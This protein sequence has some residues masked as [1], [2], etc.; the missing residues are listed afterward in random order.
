MT[1]DLSASLQQ[2]IERELPHLGALPESVTDVRPAG[3]ETWSPRE[4]MGHLIDSA[5]NN[6]IRFARAMMEPEFRGPPY[7]QNDW[8]S[9]HR[10]Q[11]MPWLKIVDFWFHYNRFLLNLLAA[12]PEE[13][14]LTKCYVGSGEGVTLQFL[15][16]D[17]VLHMQHHIDHLL[18]RDHV[19]A[20]PG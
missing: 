2:L 13:K 14:L 18:A 11:E 3:D 15:I 7:A 17:Y 20:Y 16:E 5:A 8:V 4:E 10:Y 6:H 1:V 12:V 9:V 19:T